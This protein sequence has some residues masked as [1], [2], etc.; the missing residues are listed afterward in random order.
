[1]KKLFQDTIQVLSKSERRQFILLTIAD[2]ALSA[3]DIAFLAAL[4]YLVKFYTNVSQVSQFNHPLWLIAGFFLLFALKNFCGYHIARLQYHFRAQTA[5]RLSRDNMLQYLHGSYRDYIDI[6]S[7][8]QVR[9]IS[10]QPIEFCHYIIGGIQQVFS[11]AM[12]VMIAVVAIV[13]YNPLLFVLL[14]ALLTPPV[15]LTGLFMKRK[16]KTLRQDAKPISE[17]TLQYLQEGLNGYVEGN[18][19]NSNQFFTKRYYH[20]QGKINRFLSSQQSIQHLPQRLIEVFA[21]LGLMIL[22]FVHSWTKGTAAIPLLTIGAFVAAAYKII[23][24]IV[25]IMNSIGQMRTYEFTLKDLVKKESIIATSSEKKNALQSIECRDISFG[26]NGK[27]ILNNFSLQLNPGELIGFADA[28]GTGK[29]TVINLITGLLQPRSGELYINGIALNE[30]D[31]SDYW[32]Q[33][34]Y[35]KQRNF[36]IHDT[37]EKNIVLSDSVDREKIESAI[38][39]AGLDSLLTHLPKGLETIITENGKNLSGGQRQLIMLARAL[40]KDAS[41]IIL[42]EPFSELDQDKEEQL[43]LKLR[44]LAGSGRIVVLVTHRRQTLK[45]C[46]KIVSLHAN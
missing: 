32:K 24:G 26:Y 5:S 44:R 30:K 3:M 33:V 22:V 8:I 2:L 11:Q 1:M 27:T 35:V 6:D 40:Y 12:L 38:R 34:A 10:Q 15:I 31:R 18:I 19:Y 25:K 13:I 14:L 39:E 21:V 36:F 4:L 42:D 28:S 45:H 43:M 23:P 16:L 41:L 17:R 37:I 9:R 29:S 7:S 46:T 20:F